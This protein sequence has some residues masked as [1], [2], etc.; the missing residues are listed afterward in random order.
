MRKKRPRVASP[1]EVRMTREQESVLIEFADESIASTHLTIGP[2]MCSMTDR[3]V[4]ECYNEV[5]RAQGYLRA[6]YEH[7]AI[8]IPVGQPQIEYSE[9][10]T[11]W[12]PR[13]DVLRCVIEDDESGDPVIQ[14]DDQEL[15]WEEFGGLLRTYAGWGMRIVFV[16]DDATHEDPVIEVREPAKGEG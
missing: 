12:T 9:Q 3:E 14:I 16:P 7:I 15:S 1:D 13:G 11:Q 5:V 2:A 6:T 8:E 4:L 10:C